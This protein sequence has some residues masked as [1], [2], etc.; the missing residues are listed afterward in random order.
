MAVRLESTIIKKIAHVSNK[1]NYNKGFWQT[2][3]LT[4]SHNSTEITLL[5]VYLKKNNNDISKGSN[6]NSRRRSNN[7]NSSGSVSDNNNMQILQIRF[8]ELIE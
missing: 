3:T 8:L 2:L 5:L 4:L 6:S 1:S 7:N